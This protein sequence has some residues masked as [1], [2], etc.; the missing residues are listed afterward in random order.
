MKVKV[1]YA[2]ELE[3][4]DALIEY[5]A[6]SEM[7]DFQSADGERRK[8]HIYNAIHRLAKWRGHDM[9][10]WR[11]PSQPT[12]RSWWSSGFCIAKNLALESFGR[13]SR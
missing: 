13:A 9:S 1:M 2:S 12:Q 3:A 11:N 8:M 5:T 4:L 7:Q 10:G 6:Y